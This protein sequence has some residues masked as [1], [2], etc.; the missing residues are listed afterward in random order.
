[1]EEQLRFLFWATQL[2]SKGTA[3]INFDTVNQEG[4]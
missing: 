4:S 3:E 2:N 1:M